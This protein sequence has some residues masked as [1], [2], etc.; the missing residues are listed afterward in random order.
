MVGPLKAE[1]PRLIYGLG[2][3]YAGAND[4]LDVATSMMEKI[5]RRSAKAYA[6]MCSSDR[7]GLGQ[8]AGA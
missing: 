7:K 1:T 2:Y 4:D 5:K 6:V 3:P 8:A